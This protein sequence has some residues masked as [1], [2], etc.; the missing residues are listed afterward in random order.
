MCNKTLWLKLGGD[1]IGSQTTCN[2]N[3]NPPT[4]TQSP[5]VFSASK[6][7]NQTFVAPA[8]SSASS[9][10]SQLL[11]GGNVEALLDTGSQSTI[12]SRSM[13]HEI[14]QHA[15]SKGQ[16]LP[17]LERPT[18]RLFGKDGAGGG[19]ELIIT[20]QLQAD[21][22]ADGESTS[23]TVFVQP[24]SEQKCLLGMNVLPD[25]GLSITRA[26]GEPII[27]KKDSN[28]IIAHVR[29]VQTSAIPSLK[30][31]F[32]KVQPE[33]TLPESCKSQ[34]L[35]EPRGNVFESYGLLSHEAVIS[36]CGDGC[37]Y[38]PVQKSDGGVS[39]HL[40][41][42]IEVGVIRE[43]NHCYNSAMESG[44]NENN[45]GVEEDNVENVGSDVLVSSEGN[46]VT[47]T[48]EPF[49]AVCARVQCNMTE[50]AEK[51]MEALRLPVDRFS[52]SEAEQLRDLI[53]EFSMYLLLM[54]LSLGALTL[55]NI[56]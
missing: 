31:Q 45:E 25:L 42:G 37:M 22:E 10:R 46:S 8:S 6:A 24:D 12:I 35:F 39:V 20:A 17:T 18:V 41:K 34:V 56:S 16:P 30:G 27:V 40:E 15:R 19:R 2:L 5:F 49:T 51:L 7:D 28:P 44:I 4:T 55:Y 48:D 29:L 52:E 54:T 13:L 14:G 23:V 26:N 47:D 53:C 3:P 50:R 38:V 9:Q 21:I 11:F 33:C 36:V 1:G 32:L 43:V